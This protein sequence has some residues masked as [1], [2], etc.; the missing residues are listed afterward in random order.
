MTCDQKGHKYKHCRKPKNKGSKIK[1]TVNAI[2]MENKEIKMKRKFVKVRMNNKEV[3]F[4]SD[5]SVAERISHFCL[6]RNLIGPFGSTH[7]FT[8]SG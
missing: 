5:T 2:K 4:Q 8:Q 7:N 1:N 6:A 3:K